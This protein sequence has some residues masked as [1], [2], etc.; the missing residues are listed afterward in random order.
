M[1]EST[2][3]RRFSWG[4]VFAGLAVAIGV[5]IALSLLG[6][7]IGA[8]TINP[9]A[10]QAPSANG[11]GIG[12]GVW[13]LVSTLLAIF[14][15]GW[16]AGRVA[17]MPL[18]LD[19]ALHGLVVWA[20]TTIV[21]LWLLTTALGA[22]FSGATAILGKTLSLGASAVQ[23][24]SPAISSAVGGQLQKN[25]ISLGTLSDQVTKTL[26]ETGDSRLSSQSLQKQAGHIARDASNTAK[27]SALTPQDS[28]T[29]VNDLVAR[30]LHEAKG[31]VSSADRTDL[32]N[33]V[34][35]RTH[36]SRPQAE[37][38]VD[39]WI[40]TA[41]DAQ[42]QLSQVASSAQTTAAQAG[43]AT[44]TGV[45]RGGIFAFILLLLGAAAGAAGGYT[46]IAGPRGVA[47]R[48]FAVDQP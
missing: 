17:G 33:V 12:A 20:I 14:A 30:V 37:K 24:A 35:A 6:L 28:H 27:Q 3:L 38:T 39:G 19:A 1:V 45:S 42:D 47:R 43:T 2:N 22:I 5:Q 25:G 29:S 36:E 10:G 40:S 34:M 18:R 16:V 13:L 32:V 15:G 4:A 26:A 8:S 31:T 41:H 44:A 9:A 21:T 11:F 48:R 7:G 23:S 46:S